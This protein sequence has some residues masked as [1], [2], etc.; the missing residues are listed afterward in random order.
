V[1]KITGALKAPKLADVINKFIVSPAG[2]VNE[3]PVASITV[4]L[5]FIPAP[6]LKV[7]IIEPVGELMEPVPKL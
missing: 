5:A 2:K 4:P 1:Y 6:Y 3:G 7:V